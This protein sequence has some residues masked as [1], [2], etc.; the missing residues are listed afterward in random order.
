MVMAKRKTKRMDARKGRVLTVTSV[1]IEDQTRV[2]PYELAPEFE[3]SLSGV[4]RL[5]FREFI[6]RHATTGRSGGGAPVRRHPA[7]GALSGVICN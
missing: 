2:R 5:A 6:A 1:Y 3:T 7:R 4:M